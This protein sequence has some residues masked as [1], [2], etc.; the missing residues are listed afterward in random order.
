MFSHFK[1][2]VFIV[3]LC[4][5]STYSQQKQINTL[6][7][8]LKGENI[9]DS[10]KIKIFGDLGWYYGNINTDSAFYYTKK[11][12]N[13]SFK[14]NNLK[15]IGQSYNDLGIIYY[16]TS[17]FDSAVYYYKKSLKTRTELNDSVGIAG[18]YSKIGIAF[19]KTATLDSALFFNNKSIRIYE[20]LGLKRHISINQNNNANIYQ[21]LNQLDKALEI[22]FDILKYRE[23]TKVP[24]DLVNSYTNIG[25][26]Y[27]KKKKYND[28]KKYYNKALS[29]AEKNNFNNVLSVIYNNYGSIYNDEGNS[30]LT[31]WYYKKAYDIRKKLND[32]Y[33]LASTTANLGIHYYEAGSFNKANIYLQ[34][35]VTLSKKINAKEIELNSYRFLLLLNAHLK[36]PDSVLYYQKKYDN[37]NN[38][39]LNSNI[40]KQITEIEAKYKTEKKEKEISIQ[41]EKLLKQELAL[42]NK[43]LYTILLLAFI[44]ILSIIFIGIYKKNQ[45]KRKQLQK[46]ID[47]KDALATITTQ[48][49]LQEQRLRISRDLHDNIGS[50]LTFIISSIDNLKYISKDANQKLKDKLSNISSFTSDTIHQLRDTI[51]AMNKSEISVED[52][53]ARVLSFIEKAK[54]ATENIEFEIVEKIDKNTSFSSLIGMNLFRVIQEAINN[55]IKYADASKIEISLQKNKNLFE[56]LIKDNGIGF[57]LNTVD[58]GNGLSNMEERMN[59]INGKVNINSKLKSG[60]EISISISLKNTADDV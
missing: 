2:L 13:L 39:I 32:V 27:F 60:T 10:L 30:K 59:N 36:Q 12:L 22:H 49:K 42:K 31:L 25:N 46:E 3:L 21:S 43:T 47:L 4:N 24:I 45:F 41:K 9:S 5:F 55:A 50:Q 56:V 34:E 37:L 52:L 44:I 8:K 48:N 29:I 51:W 26:I 23:T 14:K 40:T 7:E 17:K 16:R 58:L 35:S 11:G 38:Q 6:K 53:H 33:G 19:Q 15:G 20:N 28:S 57:D 1:K 18:L 54:S